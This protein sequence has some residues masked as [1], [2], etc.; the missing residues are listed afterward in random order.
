[1]SLRPG[2]DGAVR[3]FLDDD[4]FGPELVNFFDGGEDVVFLRQLMRFAVVE[5]EAVHSLEKLEQIGQR[6]VEPE[7]HGIGD[8][9]FGASHLV[10]DVALE[11]GGNVCEQDERG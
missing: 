5:N 1:M 7:V 9:E 10:E 11:R 2:Q 4:V 3:P 6:Y 8:D